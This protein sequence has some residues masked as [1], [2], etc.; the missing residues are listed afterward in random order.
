MY[1]RGNEYNKILDLITISY[2]QKWITAT[3]EFIHRGYIDGLNDLVKEK[4]SHI[5]SQTKGK[6][7][8][9]KNI[10]DFLRLLDDFFKQVKFIR[11]NEIVSYDFNKIREKLKFLEDSDLNILPPFKS[12]IEIIKNELLNLEGENPFDRIRKVAIWLYEK[13]MYQEFLT[14]GYE[15]LISYII[16]K[17][18]VEDEN[19]RQQ[20][21]EIVPKLV[22]VKYARLGKVE[23]KLEGFKNNYP[24]IY[25]NLINFDNND[26]N[27]PMKLINNMMDARN[28]YNHA[29][30][31]L[32]SISLNKLQQRLNEFYNIL[33]EFSFHL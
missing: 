11:T 30:T 18:S 5:L 25:E 32:D 7:K 8:T 13:E 4:I 17:L 20:L 14:L 2:F 19:L 29:F 26:N 23:L 24:D 3:Y 31:K 33:K 12:L 21:R 27:K 22:K 10:R 1:R 9:A 16:E 15:F 6:D 28:G